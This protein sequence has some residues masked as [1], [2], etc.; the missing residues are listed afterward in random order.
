MIKFS[1]FKSNYYAM[2]KRIFYS[3]CLILLLFIASQSQAETKSFNNRISGSV[4]DSES[5]EKLTGVKVFLSKTTFSTTTDEKGSYKLENIQPGLYEVVFRNEGYKTHVVELYLDRNRSHQFDAKLTASVSEKVNIPKSGD[6]QRQNYFERFR[7]ILLGTAD[8]AQKASIENPS[9]VHLY[10]DEKNQLRANS[11]EEVHIINEALGYE[12]FLTI[13]YFSWNLKKEKGQFS[14][15]IRINELIP[16]DTEEKQRWILNRANAY[17]N[18]L[19]EFLHTLVH[20]G[21]TFSNQR[22]ATNVGTYG[23]KASGKYSGQ[24]EKVEKTE[25]TGYDKIYHNL[26]VYKLK[27][28]YYSLITVVP[29]YKERSQFTGR[30]HLFGREGSGSIYYDHANKISFIGH[31]SEKEKKYLIVDDY[32]NL[33]NPLEIVLS[34]YWAKRERIGNFLPFNYQPQS[35]SIAVR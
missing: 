3:S 6:E 16:A 31:V 4:V 25:Q 17:D 34:G 30:Y 18:S 24:L 35:R 2:R 8:I 11:E 15:L 12:L 13:Q 22:W 21:R 9:A 23:I 5:G 28:R 26:H 14:N 27:P 10:V 32:G 33:M 7:E 29:D 19:R 20:K 1:D